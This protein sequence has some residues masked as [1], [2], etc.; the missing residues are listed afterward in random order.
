MHY[1]KRQVAMSDISKRHFLRRLACIAASVAVGA[2]SLGESLAQTVRLRLTPKLRDNT[3]SNTTG[4]SKRLAR[5]RPR[6][7]EEAFAL[8]HRNHEIE[9]TKG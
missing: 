9:I 4:F 6:T 7:I 5:L 8:A 3:S 1:S 2:V